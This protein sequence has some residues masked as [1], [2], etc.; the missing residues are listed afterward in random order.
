MK[1]ADLDPKKLDSL[2]SR[3]SERETGWLSRV[4]IFLKG[5]YTRRSPFKERRELVSS[6]NQQRHY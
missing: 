2:G 5:Y 1:I 3:I 4:F 6:E